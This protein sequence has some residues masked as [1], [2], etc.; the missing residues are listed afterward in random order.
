MGEENQHTDTVKAYRQGDVS[1]LTAVQVPTAAKRVAG[2]PILARGEMT[3]HTHRITEGKVRLYQLAT[4]LMYLRVLSEFA[5][6]YHEEHEDII[7]PKGNY[8]IR[9]QR[10]FDF[11]GESGRYIGTERTTTVGD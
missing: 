6:L 11:V 7:L 2:E 1:I 10:E 3:G 8:E 4:G 9:C 5:K